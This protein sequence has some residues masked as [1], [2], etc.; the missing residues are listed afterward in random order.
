LRETFASKSRD[1]WCEQLE[2]TDVCFAPVLSLQ[3]APDHPHNVARGTFV[4]LNGVM[5]PA[6]APRFSATPGRIQSPPS[7]IGSGSRSALSSW[8]V[9]AARIDQLTIQGIIPGHP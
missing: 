7:P 8:G 9:S 4:D 5:T 6:P 1:E 3:E 2:N